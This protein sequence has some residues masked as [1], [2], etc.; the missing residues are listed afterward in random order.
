MA[1]SNL[2]Q[3]PSV[4]PHAG[5]AVGQQQQR[6]VGRSIAIH[7]KAVIAALDRSAAACSQRGAGDLGVGHHEAERRGHVRLDHARALGHARPR[8]H[9]ALG[10]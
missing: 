5:G 3:S 9:A 6:V 4:G 7:R 10:A 1:S 2:P 8:D